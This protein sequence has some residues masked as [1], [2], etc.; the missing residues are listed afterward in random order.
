LIDINRGLIRVCPSDIVFDSTLYY[1]HWLEINQCFINHSIGVNMKT[2]NLE[3]AELSE[4]SVILGN[5]I[6]ELENSNTKNN[7]MIENI[8]TR[9]LGQAKLVLCQINEILF[10][11]HTS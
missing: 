4:L 11:H 9:Q 8:V 1:R 5:R 7:Q 2:L 3:I 10:N 6:I